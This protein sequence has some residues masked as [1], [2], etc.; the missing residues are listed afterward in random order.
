MVTGHC[1]VGHLVLCFMDVCKHDLKLT[2]IDPDNWELLE[3]ATAVG[4]MLFEKGCQ[5]G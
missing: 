3:D 5:K 1:P 2:G 4:A